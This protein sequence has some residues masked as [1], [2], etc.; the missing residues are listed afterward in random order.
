MPAAVEGIEIVETPRLRLERMR[1]GDDAEL[2]RLL[3]DPRVGDTLGGTRT[4]AQTQELLT[5]HLAHWDRHGYG[6]WMMRDR[7]TGAFVGRGGLNHARIGDRD[8]LEVGWA[9][10]PERQGEGLATELAHASARIALHG[11]GKPDVVSFTLPH[12][13]A[14]RRVMEKA[15]LAF[16]KDVDYKGRPHVL[17]RRRADPA[18]PAPFAWDRDQVAVQLPG[19]SGLFTTRRGGV[20]RGAF[21]TLNLGKLTDD[22]P[23][24]VDANRE[25]LG[26]HTG[27]PWSRVCY[28]RQ[29]HGARVRRATEPPGVAR[30][31]ADEDG[32]AT[33]LADAACAVFVADCAPVLLASDGA[34]AALHGGWRGLADGILAEGVRA[35]RDL[36]V[37]GEI[38][39]AVGP[40]A[41]GCCY[42]VGE[43]V[44]ARFAAHD[45]RRGERRLAL[46]A[47][48]RDQL[49]AAGVAAIHDCGICTMCSDPS[50]LFS[51]RRDAGRT[52]RQAGLVW[53]S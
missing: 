34:V 15:G 1:S 28:G 13:A 7:E 12:N 41:R 10:V 23:G 18:L 19:A 38:H 37:H 9:V 39:A 3:G 31:Y 32:Q 49:E 44:H 42:E 27:L 17:Y 14:S 45:A 43:E 6:L 30:P 22:E 53:R 2:V 33:A 35:L 8:E 50:L 29:V 46:E 24:D 48:V 11:L 5:A 51:H 52:G 20:S 21:S 47:V 40:S 36:G 26:A 16:E 4:P 25:R